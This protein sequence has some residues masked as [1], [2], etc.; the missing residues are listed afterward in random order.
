MHQLH[1]VAFVALQYGEWALWNLAVVP[2]FYTTRGPSQ[3]HSVAGDVVSFWS[4]SP[5]LTVNK[6]KDSE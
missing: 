5:D 2:W 1:Q 4:A 6:T 3:A